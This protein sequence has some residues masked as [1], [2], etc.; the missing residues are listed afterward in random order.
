MKFTFLGTGTSHGVPMIGCSCEVCKSQD[1]RN[2]RR[3]SSLYVVT[4]HQHILFDTPPDFRDQALRFGVKRIDA[5]FLTHAHA[6]HIYGFDD[7]RRFSTMQ[8]EHIPV[9]GSP[10]TIKQMRKK[11]DYVDRVSYGFESVPRVLFT[12]LVQPVYVEN[13]KVTPLPVSHGTET[14][15]GFLIEGDGKKMAYIPDCNGIPEESFQCLENLDAMILDGLRP[16]V[17]PTHFSIS[18]SVEQL[19]KIGA[20]KSFI[21]HL[22]HNSE[23]HDLQARLGDAVTVPWD[24]MEVSL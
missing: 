14:I 15:Y 4:E 2:Y 19:D 1:H 13:C 24:G 21:T 3:R 5:V 10:R 22:T 6:D 12:G 20:R 9:F 18:E 7:V 11:F 23:H 16:Q 8:E 17:H